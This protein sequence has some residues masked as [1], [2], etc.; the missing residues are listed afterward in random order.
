VDGDIVEV[1]NDR[2]TM[3]LPAYV[4]SRMTPGSVFIYA[5]ATWKPD[6]RGVDRGGCTNVVNP[7]GITYAQ[8][9]QEATNALVE[10]RKA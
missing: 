9:G 8:A 1:F 10:V 4:T 5:H 7:D 3:A 2:G 6:Q